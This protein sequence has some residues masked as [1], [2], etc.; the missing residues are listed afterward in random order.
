[1]MRTA[2]AARPPA[3]STRSCTGRPAIPP[4][5]S[6]SFNAACVP[7]SECW[8]RGAAGPVSGSGA[9]ILMGGPCACAE[10]PYLKSPASRAA[11]GTAFKNVRRSSSHMGAISC[12][13]RRFTSLSS[14]LQRPPDTFGSQRQLTQAD[15][16]EASQRV[17]DR[18]AHGPE[19]ALAHAL[20]AER[21]GPVTVLHEAG[22]QAR[23]HVVGA[24]HAVADEVTVQQLPTVIDHLFEQR[25]TEALHHGAL[26]LGLALL[27]I[28]AAP[29]VGHRRIGLDADGARLLVEADL[30]A[31]HR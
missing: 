3:S 30:G 29:D 20:G 2:S 23:R 9:P 16:G 7:H 15:A 27:G 21:S 26:V 11:P 22:Q 8:P 12:R 25:V 28:D 19:P 6:I 31:T 24:R 17:G 1:M 14:G 18:G 13:R 4:L 5:A 10:W